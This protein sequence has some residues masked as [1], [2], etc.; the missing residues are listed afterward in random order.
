M[1]SGDK[2]SIS[3]EY[4]W[5][6]LKSCLKI[7]FRF[8][9][10]L[11]CSKN[12]TMKSVWFILWLHSERHKF[13]D[14]RKCEDFLWCYSLQFFDVKLRMHSSLLS[15]F[16]I[17]CVIL[18]SKVW[19]EKKHLIEGQHYETKLKQIDSSLRFYVLVYL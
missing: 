12:V 11:S 2:F 9:C 5:F 19:L 14:Y 6:F 4:E 1:T 10:L 17:T 3:N 8:N 13:Y 16:I 18:C 15:W 7:R